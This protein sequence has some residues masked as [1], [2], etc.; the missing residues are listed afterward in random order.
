M[1]KELKNILKNDD[2]FGWDCICTNIRHKSESDQK[3]SHQ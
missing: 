1:T 3:G 2:E